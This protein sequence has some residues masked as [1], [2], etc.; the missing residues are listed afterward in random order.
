MSSNID[1]AQVRKIAKLGRLRLEDAEVRLFQEQL[2]NIL[3]YIE[4]LNS[5]DV[6]GKEPM[7]HPLPVTGVLRLDV[8]APTFEPDQALANAPQRQNNYFKVPAVLD[9]NAGA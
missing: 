1:E 9:P 5:V 6:A 3:G 8:P 7:A 2:G 4:Q